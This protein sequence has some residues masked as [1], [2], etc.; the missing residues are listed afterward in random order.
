MLSMELTEPR[1]ASPKDP[2]H[3][4]SWVSTVQTVEELGT[5]FHFQYACKPKGVKSEM[6]LCHIQ[7]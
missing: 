5:P 3:C 4:L 7:A 1:E 2:C 6:I